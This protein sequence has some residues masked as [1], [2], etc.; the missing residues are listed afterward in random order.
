VLGRDRIQ[1]GRERSAAEVSPG[2]SDGVPKRPPRLG[3]APSAADLSAG[4]V[5]ALQRLAGNRATAR[6]LRS[7]RIAR[8]PRGR[9]LQR[10][11]K[12]LDVP[13]EASDVQ[14][15]YGELAGKQRKYSKPQY[16]AMW[17]DEQGRPLTPHE[18]KT[19]DRGCIGIAAQDL[20]D[21][22]PPLDEM[23]S[24]FE[25]AQAAADRHNTGFHRYDKHQYAVFGMLFWSNQSD[26]AKEREHSDPTAFLPD[27]SGRIDMAG[28]RYLRQEPGF[29]KFDFGIWD[30]RVA[31]HWH[32]NHGERADAIGPMMVFQSTREHFAHWFKDPDS[33]EMRVSYLDFDRAAY[34][35]AREMIYD[36][37]LEK[38]DLTSPRFMGPDGQPDPTLERVF[39]GK[40]TLGP[41]SPSGPVELVQQALVD[42]GYDLGTTG[43]AGDGVDGVF[44][45]RTAK[46]VRQ[47]KTDENLGSE[48]SGIVGRGT[49]YRLDDLFPE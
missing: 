13:L 24:T 16:E 48:Q 49:I 21:Y 22:N 10:L 17:E 32:A 28:Y 31:S 37:T 30:A 47:F 45:R 15:Q 38:R 41:G 40:L 4:E 8:P 25:L 14:P 27:A 2:R 19:I 1:L 20:N 23:Y 36:P 34:G 9:M 18:K 42:R 11:G 33:G 43:P 5:V 26:D 46:A 12:P 3:R 6:L 35:V 39:R 7:D 44:G 29:I